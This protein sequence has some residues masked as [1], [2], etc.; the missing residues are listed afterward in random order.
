M[1]DEDAPCDGAIRSVV[2]IGSTTL[3]ILVVALGGLEENVRGLGDRGGGTGHCI[4]AETILFTPPICTDVPMG[5]AA[6]FLVICLGLGGADNVIVLFFVGIE[7]WF[8]DCSETKLCDEVLVASKTHRG[9]MPR[10]KE[11]VNY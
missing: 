8:L 11:T 1:G 7:Q 9:M 10:S 5:M 6:I 4:D 3:I 2:F